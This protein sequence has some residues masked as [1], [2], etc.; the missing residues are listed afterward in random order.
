MTKK[1]R[2]YPQ[3]FI[4][5]LAN[6]T[7][8]QQA[9]NGTLSTVSTVEFKCS[10]GNIY[11]QKITNHIKLSTGERK[12]GHCKEC[13]KRI[14]AQKYRESLGTS[15][16]YPDWFIED[17]YLEEDK[18]KAKVGIL[19]ADDKVDF[20]CP[21]CGT[22]YNQRV[23]SHITLSTGEK[24]KGCPKCG[25]KKQ[26]E[27]SRRTKGIIKPYPDWF[28]EDL[29]LDE[30]KELAKIKNFYGGEEK[31]FYCN[32]HCLVYT[33][34]VRNHIDLKTHLHKAGCPQ[35]S[36]EK[37]SSTLSYRRVFPQWFI[38]VLYLEEDKEK[39]KKGCLI[40]SDIVTL[41][42]PNH[43]EY[44][45]HVYEILSISTLEKKDI[46]CPKCS[47]ESHY[48]ELSDE[49]N[50]PE[51]FIEDLYYES[52]KEKARLGLLTTSEKAVFMCN[53]GHLYE[54]WIKCHIILSKNER[55]RGCPYCS[56]N[57]SR[58][59]INIENYIK[60]LGFSTEHRR[61][62]S[63]ILPVFE[64]DIYIPE[65]KIGIEYNGS[66]YHKTLPDD[67]YIKPRLYHNQKYYACIELGIRLIS[68]FDVDWEYRKDKIKQ[69]LKDL[70]TPP[71]DRI[72]ARKCCVKNISKEE[73]NSMYD[74]YHLLGKTTIQDV[75]Y[76][77]FYNNE[78][79]SCMSFQ[80]GR[81]KEDKDSVWCLT[82]F[83]TTS[84]Y[85][86]I[87]GAS[88]L[89][90]QFEKDFSPSILISYSDNDFF[91]GSVYV[92]LGFACL[93]DTGSPRYYWYLNEKELKR[94]QCQLKYLSKKYPELYKESLN[95]KVNKE[96]YIM[97]NLGAKKVYRSGHTKWVK[98]YRE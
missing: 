95:L 26:I 71:L 23:A 8:K 16:P 2:T 68:I 38:N 7:D 94:E 74:K 92:K 76:G 5:E 28:I 80:K 41:F 67:G 64:L 34:K 82:R 39:A 19:K 90:A 56:K 88:K 87:G 18:E 84:G 66:Y 45:K 42:C 40:S 51:W 63:N 72:Y 58:G 89:L 11:K 75:S 36:V 60:E 98:K 17:L 91:T 55:N 78:L 6:Q 54:Q 59:E 47:Y 44:K 65:K 83:V 69:Y 24:K 50:F 3:W 12:F 85:S 20:F 97:L 53:K 33:Q 10:C 43:G 61:F 86:I 77:L 27:S 35:C 1:K 32:K 22:I 4:E 15:K 31:Q 93:G 96:D 70:L 46:G 29:Y 73:A 52:D 57:R 48:K 25:I 30:D 49:R 79:L 21:V 81:Y 62:T 13:T 9:I 37:F 14:S